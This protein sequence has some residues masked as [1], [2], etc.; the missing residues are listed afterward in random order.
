MA[1]IPQI[2][3]VSGIGNGSTGSYQHES[4]AGRTAAGDNDKSV[5]PFTSLVFPNDLNPDNYYPEAMCFTIKK[6]ISLNLNDVAKQTGE[7]FDRIKKVYSDENA[8][9]NKP[10]KEKQEE[11]KAEDSQNKIKT[12]V[13]PNNLELIGGELITAAQNLANLR[14]QRRREAIR[15]GS[16]IV[17]S[18]YLN[19][20]SSIQ[21]NDSMNWEGRQL[22][23]IGA[24]TKGAIDGGGSEGAIAGEAL[25]KAGILAGGAVGG[26]I[27]KLLDAAKI[28]VGGGLGAIIGGV[29]GGGPIQNAVEASI[30]AVQNPYEE[31]MFSGITFRNF[32]F[33]FI[34][35][36]R[37]QA[38]IE[39]VDKLIKAFRRYSRPSFP[40]SKGKDGKEKR[41]FGKAVMNYPHEFDIQF[42][43]SSEG[44]FETYTQN[45]YLP[46]IKTCVLESIATNYTPNGVW[47]AYENGTP[48][49]VTLTLGFKEKELVMAGEITDDTFGA[50]GY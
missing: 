11:G 46:K 49:A 21:Y 34:F 17:G 5:K 43:T 29:A 19:M 32:N 18:I 39:T 37:T 15:T 36:P 23:A 2:E 45:K 50:H 1:Q 33:D 20:P 12:G 6:R 13:S 35:R 40:L 28:P 7:S 16:N 24:I 30:G 42:L 25:G 10:V 41:T 9:Q 31:M 48:V 3:T 47:A 8:R 4:N 14:D 38:E 44:D 26:M 22:G 27:G